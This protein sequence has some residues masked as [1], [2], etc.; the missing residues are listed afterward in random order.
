[1]KTCVLAVAIF[2]AATQ[3]NA[4]SQE[5]DQFLDHLG[6]AYLISD[7]CPSLSLPE[8]KSL[9]YL[10]SL[11]FIEAETAV[12]EMKKRAAE[13]HWG[14]RKDR[15]DQVCLLGWTRYGNTGTQLKGL[16]RAKP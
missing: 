8:A 7:I 15:P 5:E 12:D 10:L 1:M 9:S 2:A 11:N 3:A 13:D 16:L 4:F 6:E 14:I